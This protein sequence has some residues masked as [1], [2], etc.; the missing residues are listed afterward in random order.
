MP[1]QAFNPDGLHKP[2][3]YS[4]VVR[5]GNTVYIAGQTAQDAEGR[6]VGKDDIEAQAVQVFENLRIALASVEGTMDDIVQTRT[7]ITELSYRE[8]MGRVRQRYFQ[9][10]PPASTLLVVK[11]LANPDYLIEVDAV[12]VLG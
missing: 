4:Q 9:G 10:S 6:L 2:E 1:K 11:G 12:A 8:A 5:A 3:R 7:Y